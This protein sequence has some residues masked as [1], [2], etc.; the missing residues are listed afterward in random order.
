MKF[1]FRNIVRATLPALALVA[2]TACGGGGDTLPPP[3]PPPPQ[4]SHLFLTVP[5]TV[6]ARESFPVTVTALDASNNTVTSYNGSVLIVSSDGRALVPVVPAP[7]TSGG[8]VFKVTLKTFGTYTLAATDT[9]Q[10]SITGTSP[11]IKVEAAPTL[12]ITS[13]MPPG[14]IVGRPY[15]RLQNCHPGGPCNPAP[16]FELL[17]SGGL[18]SITWNWALAPGSSFPPGL[19]LA[20]N[21]INGV[22][23]LGS[24]GSY[25]VIVTATDSGTPAAQAS[26]PYTITIVNPPPPVIAA[27]PGPPG[28]TLNQPYN[29]QFQVSGFAPITVSETGALPPGLAPLPPAGVL[30]GTPTSADLYPITVHATDAAGQVTPQTFTIGVFQ[31]GFSP[32]GG[33]HA[34]RGLH[35]ATLLAS[36]QVLVTG[37]EMQAGTEAKSELYTP[38]NGSFATTASLQVARAQHTATLLCDL[39]ALPCANPKVLVVGGWNATEIVGSAELYDPT[40]G[41]FTLTVGSPATARDGHTA[42][43][44][45]SGKV[46]IA[47]GEGS[48]VPALASAELFDPDTGTF[49]ATAAPMASARY[50][51]TATLLPDGRVLIAGGLDA[52]SARLDSAELYDPMAETFSTIPSPM[53]VPR[54]GHSA[55]LLPSGKVLIAGGLDSSNAPVVAAELYAPAAVAP[56][57]SFTATGA[58]V[59]PRAW[60]RAVLLPSAQVLIVGGS[61]QGQLLQH[62]E[63]YDPASGLFAPTGGMQ[64][65]RSHHTLTL[66]GSGSMVLV[67]GGWNPDTIEALNTGEVYQ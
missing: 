3:P 21:L 54:F 25:N 9:I 2:M 37:G 59:T 36:G 40:A 50:F 29:Y 15:I 56:A 14:G 27:L 43:R 64:T 46:L 16:H 18:G 4:A 51:H 60:H 31:H 58:L 66:L 28:A 45:L 57:A 52:N 13:G 20:G 34:M 8:G 6:F 63:I 5:A 65:G 32:T 19:S 26:L 48:G 24:A 39:A 62:A 33:M 41:S 49:S 11:P 55:T 61:Y 12:A 1:A 17:A 7:L 35:T 22:P 44:L 23:P 42:T 10:A 67:V 30:A 47:G 53:T 38:T